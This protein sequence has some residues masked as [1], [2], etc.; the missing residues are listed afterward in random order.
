MSLPTEAKILTVLFKPFMPKEQRPSFRLVAIAK[1]CDAGS[2]GNN[3]IV[4][5]D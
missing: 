2:G 3:H 1:P 4:W 5:Y